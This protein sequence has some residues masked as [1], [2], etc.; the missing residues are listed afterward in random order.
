MDFL[1]EFNRIMVSQEELALATSIDNIPNVRIVNFYYDITRKGVVYFSTF[2]NNSKI[3]KFVKNNVVAFTTI[4][5]N[6]NEHIRVNKTNIHKS[7]LTIF[8]FKNEFIKKIPDY[9]MTI[10]E[11]GNQLSLYEIHFRQAT[12]TLDYTQSDMITL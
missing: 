9:E 7:D 8:D 5:S 2:S 12:I 3:E 10:E 6:E 1:Q 11:A 4:P